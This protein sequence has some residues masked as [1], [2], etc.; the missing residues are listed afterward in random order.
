MSPSSPEAATS[1]SLATPGWYSSRWPTISVLPERSAAATARSASSTD[2]ASGFSTK[3]CLPASSTRSASAPWVGTGVAS[4]TASSASSASRSSRSAVKRVPGKLGAQR[5]RAASEASQ[6][7]ASSQ[8]G[9]PAKLRAR[10]GP[11]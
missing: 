8:P 11:Q 1:L 2:C 10:F 4:T 5:S 3:Q 7:H 6:H 9:M